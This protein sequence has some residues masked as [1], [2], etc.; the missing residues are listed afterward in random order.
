M[1]NCTTVTGDLDIGDFDND[2]PAPGNISNITNFNGL[3]EL[4]SVGGHLMIWNNDVLTNIDGLAALTSVGRELLIGNNDALMRCCGL[5]PLFTS[6][7]IGGGISIYDNVAGCNSP[8]EIIN[9]GPCINDFPWPLF[10]SV[11]TGPHA[12]DCNGE[13]GGNPNN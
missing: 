11:I 8:E 10:L 13:P 3:S 12:A 9:A 4:T 5:Y 1:F 7:T 2:D 6:G